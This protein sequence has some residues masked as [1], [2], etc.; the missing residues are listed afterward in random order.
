MKKYNL[1]FLCFFSLSTLFGQT[2]AEI[3]GTGDVTPYEDQVVSTSGIVT[4]VD[5]ISYFIQD[6]TAPR[7]GIYV[8]DATQSP[9][10]GDQINITAKAVEFFEVTELVDVTAFEVVSSGNPLPDY[11]EVSTNDLKNEDYEGMLVKAKMST[12]TD[13]DLGFAEWQIDDGS[14]PIAVDDLIYLFAPT[15]NTIYTV[16]GPLHY[17]FGAYKILPRFE[18]DIVNELPLYFT[19][20]PK[21]S[22]ITT[23]SLKLTWETN[24]AASA[25]IEYGLTP[26]LEL[27]TQSDPNPNSTEHS[28]TLTGLLPATPY[29]IRATSESG[30]DKTPTSIQ[31]VS[32]V[33]N[34]TGDIKVYFNHS[35]D[36]SLATNELAVSTSSIIDTI[37][38][39]INLAEQSLDITMYEIENEQIVNAINAA[40]N[41]G[42]SVR[43][44]SDD[45]GTNSV[46]DNLNI[47]I[48]L[49]KGNTEG[50]MHDKFMIVDRASV[51]GSWVMTGSM[52]Q[53]INNLGWD[54][55]NIICIQDQAL[56][57][58]FYLEFN[59]MWG[60][61]SNMPDAANAKFGMDKIDNTPHCF[62]I[63]GRPT[64]LYF[65][66]S[67][68]TARQIQQRI[69]AAENELAFAILV[70]TENS[71]GTAV[72]EAHERGLNVKGI[73]DYVDFG[74]S[75][76]NFLLDNDVPVLDYQNE[77]G[78]QWP[79]GPTLHHK[80]AIV[81]YMTGDHPILITGSHNWT[82][83]ANSIHDENTLII[84]D[85][86]LANIYYQE[87]SA[88]YN[89]LL[90]STT[91]IPWSPLQVHPNP[92]NDLITIEVLEKGTLQ[93]FDVRGQLIDQEKVSLGTIN[94]SLASFSD[95][96][97]YVK[98][99]NAVAKVVLER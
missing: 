12:C 79:D 35:V 86:T 14:G 20:K 28:I 42:V 47:D 18:A 62:L 15:L 90:N 96:I 78:T 59:E 68:G 39:Y 52:N 9:S 85:A 99:G 27:G 48:P 80:Y 8:Y 16:S 25:M 33:S 30:M 84:E 72:K 98:V 95:G 60:S 32:T 70:F 94:Y 46:L 43:Y 56:A 2:I 22:E 29:Y 50:I 51:N 36:N 75:E 63:D 38:S 77:D 76:F 88:R 58:A 81:D 19:K 71:L 21:E 34:S 92:S 66:P 7:S 65:S 49:V 91:A 61:T 67:D 40:H 3:Q 5:D 82:A 10:L 23:N 87:F 11:V 17:S 83:S 31:V 44:I 73:I 1:L 37:I 4:A 64:E 93:V 69:D 57:N 55:N 74:G 24:I 53:T 13:T 45:M 41:R 89:G 97:Y 6:G 26:A 54:F